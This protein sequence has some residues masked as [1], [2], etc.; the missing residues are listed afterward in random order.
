MNVFIIIILPKS[1]FSSREKNRVNLVTRV[2]FWYYSVYFYKYSLV[3]I[4]KKTGSECS[5][6]RLIADEKTKNSH[7]S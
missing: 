1:L 3:N 2:T 6:R 4:Y 5:D 7:L